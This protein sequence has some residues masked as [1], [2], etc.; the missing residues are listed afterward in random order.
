[1]SLVWSALGFEMSVGPGEKA[2]QRCMILPKPRLLCPQVTRGLDKCHSERRGGLEDRG[3]LDFGLIQGYV[4]SRWKVKKQDWVLCSLVLL[5]AI[6]GV[7]SRPFQTPVPS[8]V[9]WV[10]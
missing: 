9:L 7:V 1:M 5:S 4:E 2:I 8:F 3:Q 6:A 10:L